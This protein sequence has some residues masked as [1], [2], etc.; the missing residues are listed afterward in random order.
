MWIFAANTAKRDAVHRSRSK[1]THKIFLVNTQYTK[2]CPVAARLVHADGWT[3][4]ND[5]AFCNFV[6]APRK[7]F[8]R[9]VTDFVT[10]T[11][12]ILT[13]NTSTKK[14]T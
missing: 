5:E 11:V 3:D 12:H 10:Y 14:C 13:F 7:N 1:V 9:D 4:S 8:V 6:N 2:I